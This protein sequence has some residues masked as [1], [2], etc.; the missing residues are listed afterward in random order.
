MGFFIADNGQA[1]L[2]ALGESVTDG[3][4]EEEGGDE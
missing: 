4:E 2:K 1:R 3:E